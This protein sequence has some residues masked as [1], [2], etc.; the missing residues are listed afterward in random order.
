MTCNT[1][2][3]KRTYDGRQV[4]SHDS[5]PVEVVCS[6]YDLHAMVNGHHILHG[7]TFEAP[8]GKV[9]A[10]LGPSGCGKT[11]LLR[12]LAGFLRASSGSVTISGATVDGSAFIPAQHRHIGYVPQDGGLFP[13]LDVAANVGFGV[14]RRDRSKM[15]PQLLELVGLTELAHRRPHELS[16]GQQ[17]RVALAR[18]LAVRPV[19]VLL[20]EPFSSLD[21]SLRAQVRTE[22]LALL[23]ESG[24]STILVTHDQDEAL[25]CADHL[26]LMRDGRIVQSGNPQQ[27]FRE[28]VD[29]EV[30]E[31]LNA[32]VILPARRID[33]ETASSALGF[34]KI[35]PTAPSTQLNMESGKIFIRQD[36]IG[37]R[38]F[39]ERVNSSS[40]TISAQ[41]ES[42]TYH[43]YWTAVRLRIIAASSSDY[44]EI[45]IRVPEAATPLV[46]SQVEL[47]VEGRVRWLV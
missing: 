9:T 12:V 39:G 17:Q 2:G 29:A 4:L 34:F 40:V 41:V 35:A 8:V 20:D 7:V 16:G 10:L 15:V 46:G 44:T 24:T 38:G 5:G 11:T 23:A 47:E 42:A 6:T 13:H 21:V 22:V 30:A 3:A 32:G 36:Q 25:A 43:G 19:L 1:D 14:V 26:L 27:V 31:F 45:E 37:L 18:S 28:P 33:D